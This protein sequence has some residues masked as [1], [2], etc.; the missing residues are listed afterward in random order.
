MDNRDEASTQAEK[1]WLG[2][3]GCLLKLHGK[4]E[5][6]WLHP[7]MEPTTNMSP[8]PDEFNDPWDYS[9]SSFPQGYK[10]FSVERETQG[11]ELSRKDHYLYGMF[12]FLLHMIHY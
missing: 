11:N 2:K 12:I 9:I 4:I 8:H 3:L 6:Q 10:L 1:V 7:S 5:C